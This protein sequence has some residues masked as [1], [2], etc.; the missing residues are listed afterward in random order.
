MKGVIMGV[1]ELLARKMILESRWNSLYS[2][3]GIYTIE[4]KDM[5]HEIENIKKNL[6][7]EDIALAKKEY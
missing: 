6:V 5:E 4:M 3:N 1:G 2:T 7:I